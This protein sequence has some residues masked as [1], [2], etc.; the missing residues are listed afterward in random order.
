MSVWL[1]AGVCM[2]LFVCV[3]LHASIRAYIC[4][5]TCRGVEPVLKVGG[6]VTP[7]PTDRRPCTHACMYITLFFNP[8]CFSLRMPNIQSIYNSRYNDSNYNFNVI[9]YLVV[10]VSYT[11][12]AVLCVLTDIVPICLSE[13]QEVKMSN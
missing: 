11:V 2:H 8:R 7:S 9:T 10:E 6:R 13:F 1:C 12:F 4:T 3:C 5:Y